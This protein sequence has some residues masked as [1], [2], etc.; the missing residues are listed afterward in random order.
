M[1]QDSNPRR[2]LSCGQKVGYL[3]VIIGEK[4]EKQRVNAGQIGDGFSIPCKVIFKLEFE[5]REEKI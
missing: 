4:E 5:I 1:G 2:K 3:F